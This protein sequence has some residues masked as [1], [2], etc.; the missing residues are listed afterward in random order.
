MSA[1]EIVT[2]GCR[3]NTLESEIIRR[4]A[5]AAG[6]V[7]AVVV[8]T[9]AVTAE[10][11]RQA[12]QTIRRLR[13]ERPDARIIVTGCAAQLAPATFSLMPEVDR[14]LGNAEKLDRRHYDPADRDRRTVVSDIMTARDTGAHLIE[15]IDGRSRAMVQIQQGCDHRC[16]FCTIPFAR[17]PN[18]SVPM[19]RIV[20]QVRM[21]VERGYGEIVLT[22]VDICAY[23]GD[24][25]G[26]PSLGAL[27]RRLLKAVGDL[28]RLRLSSLDPAAIDPELIAVMA[29]EPRLMPHVHLSVQAADDLVLKRMRRRHSRGQCLAIASAFRRARS[30]VVFGADLIAGFPTE[31]E[32]MFANTLSFIDEAGLTY[33]HVFPFSPRPGTPAARMPQVPGPIRRQRAALLRRAGDAA[34]VRYFAGRIGARL[35]VAVEAEGRARCA[36]F[37][38]VALSSPASPGDFIPVDIIGATPEHLI[39]A[40]A[41]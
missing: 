4:E 36:D 9:C 6:A 38:P 34:K 7:D 32:A 14:V 2:F 3:L 23:G 16:T 15:G 18:R 8:N 24:L 37:A 28:R 22:G 41:T 17:G 19:D 5:V 12:R 39:G 10:A 31:D 29:E 25:P 11:V 40:R 21:L 13:R 30:D 1:P 27:V 26:R 33:L 35:E 20:E